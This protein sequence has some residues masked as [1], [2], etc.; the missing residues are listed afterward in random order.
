MYQQTFN[1]LDPIMI[2]GKQE[3]RFNPVKCEYEEVTDKKDFKFV[4]RLDA[5][6][7]PLKKM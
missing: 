1:G 7:N 4:G 5:D 2:N 6:G 3:F